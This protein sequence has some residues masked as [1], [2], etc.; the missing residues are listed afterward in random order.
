MHTLTGAVCPVLL[1][2]ALAEGVGR[3]GDALPGVPIRPPLHVDG[4][5]EA[6]EGAYN[7]A[8]QLPQLAVAGRRPNDRHQYRPFPNARPERG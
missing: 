3:L 8:R 2:L 4:D 1:P 6:H 7:P 5:V